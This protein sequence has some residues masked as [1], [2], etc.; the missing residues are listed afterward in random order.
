MNRDDI[1]RKAKEHFLE[2]VN[3]GSLN[4][5]EVPEWD[6]V[7]Y[8]RDQVSL[9][10]LNNILQA[11]QQ[12]DIPGLVQIVIEAALDADGNRV[13]KPSDAKE[14]M[15]WADP[16]V[17]MRITEPMSAIMDLAKEGD[18]ET[19]GKSS[20]TQASGTSMQLRNVSENL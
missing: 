1:L 18:D 17:V 2:Q 7:L 4:R 19:M 6:T 11:R 12:G 13:F 14:I 16:H 10:R 8:F 20:E 9:R 15:T 3:G 5:V